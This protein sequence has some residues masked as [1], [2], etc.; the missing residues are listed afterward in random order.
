MLRHVTTVA[1]AGSTAAASAGALLTEGYLG[2]C[3]QSHEAEMAREIW[4]S[5]VSD[6]SLRIHPKEMTN[7]LVFG[8]Y[9]CV[10]CSATVA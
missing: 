4:S 10:L 6:T 7:E 8:T 9:D 2:A 5:L 1:G 3:Q